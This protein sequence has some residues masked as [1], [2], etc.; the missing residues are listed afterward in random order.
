[1]KIRL[2]A[3][4]QCQIEELHRRIARSEFIKRT[5]SFLGF[6]KDLGER[7]RRKEILKCET[8]MK[9]IVVFEPVSTGDIF[10]SISGG[11]HLATCAKVLSG[12]LAVLMTQEGDPSAE[13]LPICTKCAETAFEKGWAVK[14]THPETGKDS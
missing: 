12:G 7:E 8:M 1:M 4:V 2:E 6:S 14:H 10:G 13:Y 9:G 11:A 3:E 5:G